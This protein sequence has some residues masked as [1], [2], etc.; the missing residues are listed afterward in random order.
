MLLGRVIHVL[1]NDVRNLCFI[2]LCIST[3]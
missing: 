1:G 2:R 3:S